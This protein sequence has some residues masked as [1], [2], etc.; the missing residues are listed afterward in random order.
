MGIDTS[1][2]RFRN[3]YNKTRDI[4]QLIERLV[5]DQE[6]AGL[7]PVIPTIQDK[8]TKWPSDGIGRH[9]GFKNRF[10]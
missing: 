2:L 4:V 6:A 7:S 3:K 1:S 9:D 10:Q 5:W 8:V